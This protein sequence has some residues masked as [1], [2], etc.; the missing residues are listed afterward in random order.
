M[1]A[2]RTTGWGANP[3]GSVPPIGVADPQSDRSGNTPET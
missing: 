2:D 3:A 1:G